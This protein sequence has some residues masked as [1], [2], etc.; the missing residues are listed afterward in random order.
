[1]VFDKVQN[2][3]FKSEAEIL[4]ALGHPMRLKILYALLSGDCNVKNMQ[5]CVEIPQANISQHLIV[6]KN[7]GAI[8]GV[9]EGNQIHYKITN[10]FVQNLMKLLS[11]EVDSKKTNKNISGGKNGCFS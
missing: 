2:I 11:M 5:E 3:C 10:P 6:L 7:I 9:R 1:M 4:K 8:K